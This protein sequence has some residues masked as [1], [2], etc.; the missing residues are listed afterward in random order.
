[1]RYIGI[2]CGVTL[3]L[4]AASGVALTFAGPVGVVTPKPA[5]SAETAYRRG[6]ESLTKGEL[7]EAEAAFKEAAQ[8]QPKAIP[9]LL[10][11]A[12]V[13]L[14]QGNTKQAETYLQQ[15]LNTAPQSVEVHTAWGRYLFTQK[16]FSDAEAALQKAIVLNPQAVAPHVALGDL[17]LSGLRKPK[18]AI[19]AYRAVLALNPSHASTHYALGSAL[20]AAG[21]VAGSDPVVAPRL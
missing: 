21:Q 1:M 12:D 9:P 8:L 14:K 7:R 11:L 3:L 18:E 6:V 17:Y 2:M 19:N 5:S 15:A 13:A 4:Y 16:R 10:G 20:A